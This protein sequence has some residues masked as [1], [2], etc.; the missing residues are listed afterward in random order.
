MKRQWIIPI[1]LACLLLTVLIYSYFHPGRTD[2]H[3]GHYDRKTGQY[4]YHR[5]E[6]SPSGSESSLSQQPGSI[7]ESGTP[8]TKTPQSQE[9]LSKQTPTKGVISGIRIVK[10]VING[11]TL[12]LENGEKVRLIGVDT[13]RRN[14]RINRFNVLERKPRLLPNEW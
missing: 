14:I 3:G 11:D 5:Q 7:K 4:H 12:E 2:T 13:P 10:R 6:Y 8:Q 9:S 1:I